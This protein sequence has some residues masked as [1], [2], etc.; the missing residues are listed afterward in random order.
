MKL[1][2]QPSNKP[3]LQNQPLWFPINEQQSEKLQGGSRAYT[4]PTAVTWPPY[5]PD[6]PLPPP[7]Q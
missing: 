4:G 7:Y 5:D 1:K 3:V 2:I 6:H